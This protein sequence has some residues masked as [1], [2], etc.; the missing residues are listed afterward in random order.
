MAS[1]ILTWIRRDLVS[2]Y[3]MS[4]CPEQKKCLKVLEQ[5]LDNEASDEMKDMYNDRVGKCWHCY[6]NYKIEKAIRDLV[7]IKMEKKSV[8]ENLLHE[9][10]AKI[11]DSK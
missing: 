7:K 10:K 11:S 2:R 9:I 4:D 3:L 5:I 1:E 8:P 6:K